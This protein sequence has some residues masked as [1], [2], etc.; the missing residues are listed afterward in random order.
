MQSKALSLPLNYRTGGN[1]N[2]TRIENVQVREILL[3]SKK[4]QSQNVRK[5]YKKDYQ[6]IHKNIMQIQSVMNSM[7]E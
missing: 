1:S 6:V 2:K 3:Q 7:I 5:V 4:K